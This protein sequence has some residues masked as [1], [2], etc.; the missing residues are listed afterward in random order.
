MPR[1]GERPIKI[2]PLRG[3]QNLLLKFDSDLV[4]RGVAAYE[5]WRAKTEREGMPT[6]D[7]MDSGWVSEWCEAQLMGMEE[8]EPEPVNYYSPC[9]PLEWLNR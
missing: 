9:S 1:K 8:P 7:V 2:Y 6:E 4:W 5:L 3:R